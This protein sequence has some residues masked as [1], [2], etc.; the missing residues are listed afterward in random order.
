MAE[1]DDIKEAL[2]KKAPKE[3]PVPTKELLSTGSTLINL[4]CSGRPQGGLAMGKYVFFVG[5][6]SSGKTFLSLTCL[7]EANR[8]KRFDNYRFIFDNVEDGA[9][10]DFARYFGQGVA[11]RVEPAGGYDD[12]KQ[13]VY[14][15]TVEDFHF[16]VDDAIDNEKPFIYI[17]DSMDSLTS[18]YE[19]EKFAEKKT[20]A[21]GGKK[22]KGDYGDGKAKANSRFIRRLL[23]GL[24]RTKSILIV[25]CQTRDNIE[26]GPFESSKTFSGG[27]AIKFYACLEMWTSV[28]SRLKKTV[29][30]KELQVGIISKV[31][32]KKNRL[33]GKEWAVEV[34][35]Y[36][37]HGI[38]DIGSCVDYLIEWKHWKKKDGGQIFANEFEFKGYRE[39]LI[40]KIESENLERELR[41]IVTEVWREVEAACTVDRK[42]R[43]E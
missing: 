30:E 25:I 26:A 17:L 2:L 39:A 40:K 10:M 38:D 22:A 36:F 8:S 35:L 11:D 6:S 3:E 42:K 29:K 37:S 33:T 5:D 14:S 31:A 34:P 15:R 23:S 20:E 41:T 4:A 1:T 24:K 16:N 32:I 9:L 28:K 27:H 12:E 13:P 18:K 19:D 21:R 7:A 43:Y